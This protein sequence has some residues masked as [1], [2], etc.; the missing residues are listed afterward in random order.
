V[1]VEGQVVKMHRG[2]H[3]W[4]FNGLGVVRWKAWPWHRYLN[5]SLAFGLG[6][7]YATEE[8]PFEILHKG[9]STQLLAYLLAEAEIGL[10][11]LPA[12]TVVG[13]VHHR[14]TSGNLFYNTSAASNVYVLG[15]KF[16][17]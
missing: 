15:L 5:T 11:K 13:R 6:V 7:S 8:P 10:P 4:E 3:H 12:W 14:S 1:E 17:F 16:R 2:Q 9:G